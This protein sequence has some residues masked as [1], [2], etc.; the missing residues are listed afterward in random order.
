MGTKEAEKWQQFVAKQ[1]HVCSYTIRMRKNLKDSSAEMDEPTTHFRWWLGRRDR[2]Y[3]LGYCSG[4]PYS[5]HGC[6]GTEKLAEK[7]V[8][9]LEVIM[10]MTKSSANRSQAK[11]ATFSCCWIISRR[12]RGFFCYLLDLLRQQADGLVLVLI[13]FMQL[14]DSRLALFALLLHRSLSGPSHHRLEQTPL[15]PQTFRIE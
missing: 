15:D 10:M 9:K 3:S 4:T 8:E 2:S 11:T 7:P 1:D 5:G 14:V 13:L 6:W 12:R